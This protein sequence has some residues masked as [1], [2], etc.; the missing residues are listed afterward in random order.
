MQSSLPCSHNS[1]NHHSTII[2][3]LIRSRL[4]D[5]EIKIMLV[6]FKSAATDSINM[7]GDSAQQLI[8]MLGGSGGIPRAITAA[9][10]PGALQLLRQQLQ[11]QAAAEV[12]QAS[13]NKDDEDDKDK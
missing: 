10:I 12:P 2:A 5:T 4:G 8:K 6:R 1:I 9:D 3:G 11:T 13:N 7:F